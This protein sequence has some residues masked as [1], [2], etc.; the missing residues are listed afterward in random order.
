M[1]HLKKTVSIIILSALLTA[2]SWQND[3]NTNTPN[4]DSVN[5]QSSSNNEMLKTIGINEF[6]NALSQ[7][8]ATLIDLRTP[9]EL[10]STGIIPWA[11]NI[12]F[13]EADFRESLSGLDKNAQYLIYCQSG[14]RS[15]QSLEI[16]KELWFT[17]VQELQGWINTWFASGNQT[18]AYN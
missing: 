6:Q 7:V 1:N 5:T 10:E 3:T 18:E 13:Y 17:N 11:Q 9:G 16:M 14:N 2:C 15:G 8:D 4:A 12:N